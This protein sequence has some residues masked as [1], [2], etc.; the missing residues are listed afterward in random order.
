MSK[1]KDIAVKYVNATGHVNF[2]VVVNAKN[3]H[4][5]PDDVL[6]GKN[7]AWQVLKAQTSSQFVYPLSVS[8]AA[9]YQYGGQK[10]MAGPFPTDHGST[11]EI[12]QELESDTAILQQGIV[13]YICN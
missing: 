7:I 4:D 8:V 12:I 2:V 6:P 1:N 11:W 13:F 9:S 5:C 10:I 3:Y